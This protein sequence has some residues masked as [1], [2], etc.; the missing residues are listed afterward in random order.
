MPKSLTVDQHAIRHGE[1]V[2]GWIVV[3]SWDE[4]RDGEQDVRRTD[5]SNKLFATE[6]DAA[7]YARSISGTIDVLVKALR[8]A[9]PVTELPY[10]ERQWV[11]FRYEGLNA[12]GALE[13]QEK[14][15]LVVLVRPE[16]S[17]D[18]ELGVT[19]MEVPDPTKDQFLY[20]VKPEAVICL[21]Q[22]PFAG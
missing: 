17:F 14:T 22:S 2:A 11:K 18:G 8:A 12:A 13:M 15:G 9:G 1:P 7:A 19:I 10:R 16:N 5:V 6:Q 3:L 21:D 20:L 4:I